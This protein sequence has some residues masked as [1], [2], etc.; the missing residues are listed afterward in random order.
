M[1]L[2]DFFADPEAEA[3]AGDALG[4]EEGVEDAGLDFGAHAGG[5]VGDGDGDAGLAGAPVGGFAFAHEEAAA[6]GHDVEGIAD[7]V[8]D[9]LA[10]FSVEAMNFAAG[11]A[12]ALDADAGVVDT[13]LIDGENGVGEVA[14]VHE[15]RAGGL[16]MEAERL[17]GDGGGAAEFDLGGGEIAAG[18]VE[19][20][21]NLREVE[22]VGDGLERVVDLVGDGAGEA[23]D[24]GELFTLDEGLLGLSLLGD[25]EATRR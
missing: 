15:L 5:V 21:G 3:G 4:G 1:A 25:F 7:E 12:A 22:K 10:D 14:D 8:G 23:A 19:G 18:F 11:A 16:A 9:D 17:A 6:A 13:A 2:H 20:F 24:D